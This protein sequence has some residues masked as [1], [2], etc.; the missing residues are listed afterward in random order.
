MLTQLRLV[1]WFENVTHTH[2]LVAAAIVAAIAVEGTR[3]ND[4][5]KQTRLKLQPLIH[6]L[7]LEHVLLHLQQHLLGILRLLSVRCGGI[8]HQAVH[9]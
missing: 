9:I 3:N 8:G 6:V 7:Q 4:S 5:N 2:T 1:V